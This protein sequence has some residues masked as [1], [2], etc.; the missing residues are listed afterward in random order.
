MAGVSNEAG[1]LQMGQVCFQKELCV[2]GIIS[3]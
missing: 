2:F 1:T 3:A